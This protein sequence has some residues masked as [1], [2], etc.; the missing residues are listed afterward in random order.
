MVEV[1]TVNGRFFD[2]RVRTPRELLDLAGYVE[3][4]ARKRLARGRCEISVRTEGT[5]LPLPT[6]DRDRA[7]AAYRSLLDLR[8]E[9]APGADVPLSMLSAIF[10]LIVQQPAVDTTAA[11]AAL[12]LALD[13]ALGEVE[14]MREREG[15]LLAE[16]LEEMARR[17]AGLTRAIEARAAGMAEIHAHRLT[18]R[19]ARLGLRLDQPSAAGEATSTGVMPDPARLEQELALLADRCDVSEELSRVGIHLR[20]LTSYL[21]ASEPTGRRLDFLLQEMAREINTVGAKSQDAD[22]AHAVVELKAEI[23][24]MREQVQNVE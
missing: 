4:E 9:L 19:L 23:E 8:D 2:A 18:E 3:A 24:R 14:R 21:R 6:I 7:R 16:E 22:I 20:Q 12:T 13:A 5:I 17:A 15:Q 10:D 1:R 11:E